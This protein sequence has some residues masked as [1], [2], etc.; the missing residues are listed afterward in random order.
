MCFQNL[1]CELVILPELIHFRSHAERGN[2]SG[3][4]NKHPGPRPFTNALNT[5]PT[6][7]QVLIRSKALEVES[8]TASSWFLSR[9]LHRY[10]TTVKNLH[11]I[12]SISF[13][14]SSRKPNSSK[15]RSGVFCDH[16]VAFPKGAC[17][18]F[19][20]VSFSTS[21]GFALRIPMRVLRCGEGTIR[22]GILERHLDT[23]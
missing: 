13:R 7:I 10:N 19:P 9:F 3:K 4:R 6:L 21:R 14:S 15:S 16:K 5:P 20:D 11:C 17:E 12:W 1:S 8:S 23:R 22:P 2:S 18:V